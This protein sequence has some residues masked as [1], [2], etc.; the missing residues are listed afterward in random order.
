MAIS[1]GYRSYRGGSKASLRFPKRRRARPYRGNRRR[2]SS[3]H[4][5]L[6]ILFLL[7][8]LCAGGYLAAQ[9][10]TV[11]N[12]DGTHHLELPFLRKNAE[13]PDEKIDEDDVEIEYREPEKHEP[14]RPVLAELHAREMVTNCLMGDP[15]YILD[16]RHEA[17]SI[18]VKMR[19][20]S[21]AFAP[22]FPVPEGI[23]A[24]AAETTERLKILL[25]AEVYTVARIACFAD[26]SACKVLADGALQSADGLWTDNYARYWLDPGAESTRQYLQALC[27]EC[28]ALGFDEIALDYFGYPATGQTDR[29]R[30][31]EEPDKTAV[32][33]AFVQALR[34]ALPDGTALSLV[35]RSDPRE[36]DGL[37]PELMKTEFDRIYADAGTVNRTALL[38]ALGE[39]FD[40]PTRLVLMMRGTAA[41]GSYLNC[42]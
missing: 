40:V 41:S 22:S 24:G 37:T 14:V 33:T 32:L 29:I 38:A 20:G 2:D 23:P 15:Q 31:P 8:I 28:A 1:R 7:I 19:D 6:A 10:Y 36:G 35:L 5:G 27:T 12:E 39:D 4:G 13:E 30:Y 18:H 34:S 9:N 3:G 16:S 21:I 42:G 17:I 26:D 11:Y 25:D